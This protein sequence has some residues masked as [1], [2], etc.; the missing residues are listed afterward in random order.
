MI[1]TENLKNLPA[2]QHMNNHLNNRS[3]VIKTKPGG[4]Y[5][6]ACISEKK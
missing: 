2:S 4:L 1:I 6:S 3:G 5:V